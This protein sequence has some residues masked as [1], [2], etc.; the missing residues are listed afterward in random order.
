MMSGKA[1]F[2]VVLTMATWM[3]DFSR[4]KSEHAG[5]SRPRGLAGFGRR[6]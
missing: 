4:G 1:R 2:R 6:A 3:L 5:K